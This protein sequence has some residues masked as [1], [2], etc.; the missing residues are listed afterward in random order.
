V[1]WNALRAAEVVVSLSPSPAFPPRG[2]G[3]S[4]PE[5]LEGAY[6]NVTLLARTR[7]YLV[8]GRVR[9]WRLLQVALLWWEC[10]DGPLERE[11]LAPRKRR[12]VTQGTSS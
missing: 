8:E 5:N 1:G 10:S 9:C 2:I 3:K 12:R 7:R 4:G 11:V 6:V